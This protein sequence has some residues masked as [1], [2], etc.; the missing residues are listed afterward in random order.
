MDK[1]LECYLHSQCERMLVQCE[2][3]LVQLATENNPYLSSW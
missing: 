2:R 3:M 1:M